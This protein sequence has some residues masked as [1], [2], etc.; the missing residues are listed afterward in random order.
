[1]NERC[2][3]PGDV[4]H[5]AIGERIAD[6]V[7]EP[8]EGGDDGSKAG[9]P[10]LSKEPPS[11]PSCD[12]ELAAIRGRM[13]QFPYAG[14]CGIDDCRALLRMV[15]ELTKDR[16]AE[17]RARLSYERILSD[18]ERDIHDLRAKLADQEPK[19]RHALQVNAEAAHRI[20]ELEAKLAERTNELERLRTLDANHSATDAAW[21]ERVV[22]L[23][24][25]LAEESET[26]RQFDRRIE[27][28]YGQKRRL[29]AKLAEAEKKHVEDDTWIAEAD[30]RAEAAEARLLEEQK[31]HKEAFEEIQ[32]V[33]RVTTENL[34]TADARVRELEAENKE[35]WDRWPNH[36]E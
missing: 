4:D 26:A 7:K 25:K 19:L 31:A 23:Q 32:N 27:E 35:M 22:E 1:M 28:L 17:W 18:Q 12:S 29:E 6:A 16:D 34:K 21:R 3:W 11:L 15:D 10:S 36:R 8:Q 5:D 9:N 20:G 24:A 13:A 14:G 30:A 33:L 2:S